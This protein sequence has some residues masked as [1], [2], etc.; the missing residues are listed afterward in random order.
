MWRPSQ[1]DTS[2]TPRRHVFNDRIV[3]DWL[4]AMIF[5]GYPN[6]IRVLMT[7]CRAD[8]SRNEVWFCAKGLCRR[9]ASNGGNR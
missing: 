5:G 8:A 3:E 4:G 6:R 2:Q 9:V 7:G 1:V